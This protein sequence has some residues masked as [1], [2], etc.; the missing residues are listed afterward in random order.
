MISLRRADA[1]HHHRRR[2]QDVWL[3][4]DPRNRADPLADG[5]GALEILS[6]DR[7]PPRAAIRRG[8]RRA[9]EL[10][11]YVHEGALA[12]SDSLGSS[13]VMHAG[14][15]QHLTAGRGIRHREVNASPSD[16]AHVF[17]ISLRPTAAELA[18]SRE[19][20]RFSAAERRGRFCIVAS[21]DGREHSLR[22]Q[23]DVLIYS[24]ILDPGHH[25]V[26]ALAPDRDAWLHLVHGEALVGDIILNDGDGAGF[27]M[28][29][30]VSLTAREPS[31]LLL[32]E[33][34]ARE[35]H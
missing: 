19:Q 12:Y 7:L 30:A 6:E 9:A 15:F 20:R 31:E 28:E 16:W 5:F 17:Q 4:F 25:M 10:V 21:P 14:E 13:G 35:L 26:H 8:P 18:S 34:A 1:R 23:Q 33:L 3:T 29:R 22:I 32:F 11:T 27:T 24:T 2:K